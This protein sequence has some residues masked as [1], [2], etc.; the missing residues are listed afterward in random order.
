MS[1]DTEPIAEEPGNV[2]PLTHQRI[3]TVMAAVAVLS[4]LIS[5][6]YVSWQF[7]LGV[8]FGGILS[9]INYYWLKFSLKKV[10]ERTAH[11]ERPRF[12]AVRYLSRYLVLGGI[13]LIVF[14]TKTVPVVSVILGMASFAFAIVI[15]GFIRLFASFFKKKEI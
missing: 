10:F 9:F 11:G 5:F 4:S 6:I 1:G 12:L 15:E 8:L 13:L 2:V 14:L 7:G 3:L